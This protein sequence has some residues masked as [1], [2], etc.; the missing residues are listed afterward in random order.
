MYFSMTI[1]SKKN[2]QRHTKTFWMQMKLYT[3]GCLQTMPI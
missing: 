3:E 1:G 2:S